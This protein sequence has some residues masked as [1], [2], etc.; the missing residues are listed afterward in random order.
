MAHYKKLG[1]KQK[2]EF[3]LMRHKLG[4]KKKNHTWGLETA[5]THL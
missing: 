5:H 3:S 4:E 2:D 1:K